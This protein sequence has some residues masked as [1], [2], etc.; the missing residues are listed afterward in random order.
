[1]AINIL[2]GIIGGVTAAVVWFFVGAV[3][4]MNPFVAKWY[5]KYESDP[6][7]KNR[8][9]IKSFLINTLVFSI[10]IQCIIFAFAYQYIETLLPDT[11]LLNAIYFGIILVGVKIIPRFLDMWVQSK[12]PSVLLTIELINGAIGSFVIAFIF[13]L[14]L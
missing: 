14:L 1:M 5:K 9:N 2:L 10:L 12:Y 8:K 6:S 13:A 7:V 4:Y 11:L 3:V